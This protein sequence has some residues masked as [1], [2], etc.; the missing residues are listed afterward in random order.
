MRHFLSQKNPM[1]PSTPYPTE[2]GL[3]WMLAGMSVA[4]G[5]L[6]IGSG[7]KFEVT[8]AKSGAKVVR[9]DTSPYDS[10]VSDQRKNVRNVYKV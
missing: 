10:A 9:I 7:T 1:K 4:G 2:P 5:M 6:D 8:V 3:C